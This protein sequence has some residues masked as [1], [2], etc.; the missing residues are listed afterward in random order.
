MITY[1]SAI[2]C[3]KNCQGQLRT[4]FQYISI[5]PIRNGLFVHV[6][7]RRQIGISVTNRNVSILTLR[8]NIYQRQRHRFEVIFTRIRFI[9]VRIPRVRVRRNLTMVISIQRLTGR[10]RLSVKIIRQCITVRRLQISVTISISILMI[11]TFVYRVI[12]FCL[13]VNVRF[14]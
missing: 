5:R 7:G 11:M 6:S 9:R 13:S 2:S 3:I 8:I 14:L 10:F 4:L 1:S 12:R